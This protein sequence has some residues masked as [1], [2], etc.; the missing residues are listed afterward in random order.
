[1]EEDELQNADQFSQLLFVLIVG[2]INYQRRIESFVH[3]SWSS[4]LWCHCDN[5]PSQLYVRHYSTKV[6]S[7][8][9]LIF[10]VRGH[11]N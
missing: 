2:R 7:S 9:I 1:M 6:S 5:L 11:R 4:K 10:A 3:R 8:D